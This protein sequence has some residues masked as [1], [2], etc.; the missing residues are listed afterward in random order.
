[1]NNK[2]YG[3]L[4]VIC[5]PMF[6]GKTTELLK[7]VLWAKNG[8]GQKVK[9]FKPAFDNRYSET[10]IVSHDGLRTKADSINIWVDLE[11][12]W[13]LVVFDEVQFFT[14]PY[15]TG[16]FIN[17]VSNMLLNGTNVLATGLDMDWR[18]RP[19]YITSMLLGMADEV[20]KLKAV[21]SISGRPAGK[22]YKKTGCGESV[23]LGA[24]DLYEA[25][26][27]EYWRF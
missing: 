20:K 17:I 6:A 5:G 19:F 12:D 16:D 2:S 13:D 8:L 21:C 14:D 15:F 9:V 11:Y 10:E 3:T 1:M 7:R 24:T 22:T 25:R 23:E 4:E 18:G 27:N 26:S